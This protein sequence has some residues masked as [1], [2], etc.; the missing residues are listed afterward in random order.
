VARA[1]KVLVAKSCRQYYCGRSADDRGNPLSTDPGARRNDG[2]EYSLLALYGCGELTAAKIVGETAG[3][4]R[5]RSEAAFASYAGVAPIPHWSG[6][7][8]YRPQPLG[9]WDMVRIYFG[10]GR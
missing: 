2:T 5:F 6:R 7:T 3:V 9:S 4:S 8:N 10:P 1:L